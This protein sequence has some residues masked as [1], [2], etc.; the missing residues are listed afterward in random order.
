MLGDTPFPATGQF[1]RLLET[2]ESGLHG[3]WV[4]PTWHVHLTTEESQTL[5]CHATSLLQHRARITVFLLGSFW[6][7][8]CDHLMSPGPLLSPQHAITTFSR[9]P[10]CQLG[11][12]VVIFVRGGGCGDPVVVRLI[13]M[14]MP[15]AR[16][17]GPITPSKLCGL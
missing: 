15:R 5:E 4:S 6:D 1:Y 12:R 7:E 3:P 14:T 8:L 13:H 9:C 11:V 10:R 2:K 16:L 17:V